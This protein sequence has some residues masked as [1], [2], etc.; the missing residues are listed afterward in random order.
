MKS[1][2]NY[3]MYA[4]QVVEEEVVEMCRKTVVV[5][6]ELLL[7]RLHNV[8]VVSS[9][10]CECEMEW[11]AET[12]LKGMRELARC[13]AQSFANTLYTFMYRTRDNSFAKTKV[14]SLTPWPSDKVD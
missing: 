10:K 2:M 14:H 3:G 11:T 6:V 7:R 9:H 4:L 1:A 8:Y 13:D 12:R 5:S